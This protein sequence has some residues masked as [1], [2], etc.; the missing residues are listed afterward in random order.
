MTEYVGKE[1][2]T[3]IPVVEGLVAVESQEDSILRKG[4]NFPSAR[5]WWLCPRGVIVVDWPAPLGSLALT[6]RPLSTMV[7]PPRP[8]PRSLVCR[9]QLIHCIHHQLWLGGSSCRP[10]NSAS[11]SLI[12]EVETPRSQPDWLSLAHGT[13]LMRRLPTETSPFPRQFECKRRARRQFGHLPLLGHARQTL[14][15]GAPRVASDLDR[16]YGRPVAHVGCGRRR[17][18]GCD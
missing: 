9:P 4:E 15:T 2:V 13:P 11:F 14:M 7:G 16:R 17:G 3:S 6:A 18:R 10:L 1:P 5:Q 12:I 8:S